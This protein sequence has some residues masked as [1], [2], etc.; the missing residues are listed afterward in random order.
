MFSTFAEIAERLR[1]KIPDFE[2]QPRYNAAPTQ[3]L[4][5][6]INERGERVI[7]LMRWGL[8]PSWADSLKYGNKLI[9]IRSDTLQEKPA[10]RKFVKSQRSI[11]PVSGFYEWMPTGKGKQPMI[12]KLKSE[13]VIAL[14]GLRNTW[15]SLKGDV[16]DTFTIITTDANELVQPIHNR[17][18]VIIPFN[19]VDMW[20]SDDFTL[21]EHLKMLKPYSSSQMEYKPVSKLINNPSIDVPE[22]LDPN[23]NGFTDTITNSMNS[24]F[25]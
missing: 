13:P 4:P 20:L 19:D 7:N 10:F 18:P 14:A 16:V 24:L 2:L 15:K 22:L 9:N 25:E 6:I 8:T 17:M 21:I 23:F 1:V 12:I 3:M 11:I 5:V